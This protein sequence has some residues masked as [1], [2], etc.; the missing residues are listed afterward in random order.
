[1]SPQKLYLD[2]PAVRVELSKVRFPKVCP[3]C[4]NH[5]S[6]LSRITLSSRGSNYLN[7][8][9]DPYYTSS[10]YGSVRQK[11][12]QPK[13]KVIPIYVC[14][15]HY[16]TDDGAERYKTCCF[17]IDGLA[18]AFFFFGLLFLGDAFY[19]GLPIPFWSMAF[20]SFFAFSMFL[21]WVA[22]RPNALQRAVQI[23]GFDPGLQNILLVFKDKS[24]QDTII[25]DNPMSSELVSWIV[26]PDN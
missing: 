7:R 2:E 23:V 11:L 4:G 15:N 26:K 17:I 6:I 20:T 22:F 16:H 21:T 19:R 24:Y 5:A 12:T 1:M 9:W 25:R 3:V 14:E 8:A 13:L 18:M 10:F